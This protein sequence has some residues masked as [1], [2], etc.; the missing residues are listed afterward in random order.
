MFG[1]ESIIKIYIYFIVGNLRI[2]IHYSSD[3]LSITHFIKSTAADKNKQCDQN[4]E[5]AE[6]PKF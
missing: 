5:R 2:N 1:T 6:L 4:T 3:L